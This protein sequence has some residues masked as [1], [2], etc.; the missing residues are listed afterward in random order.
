VTPHVAQND[1]RAASGQFMAT[2]IG[3]PDIRLWR[4]IRAHRQ[5]SAT[6]TTRKRIRIGGDDAS[7]DL[8]R[9]IRRPV[10]SHALAMTLQ[11]R[12]L[13]IGEHPHPLATQII[14][15]VPKIAGFR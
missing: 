15:G 14:C 1:T 5:S 9:A 7:S 13:L 4:G 12:V 6:A 2:P 11:A 10:S 3:T 8:R